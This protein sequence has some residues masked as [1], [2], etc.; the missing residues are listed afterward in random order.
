MEITQQPKNKNIKKPEKSKMVKQR[1]AKRLAISQHFFRRL[2][3]ADYDLN[4]QSLVKKTWKENGFSQ[5]VCFERN[6]FAD[7]FCGKIFCGQNFAD[8][9]FA[10]IF[11][12]IF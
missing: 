8:N 10:G 9:F 11:L 4:K 3:R 12:R 1:E 2:N 7:F 6:F 5:W